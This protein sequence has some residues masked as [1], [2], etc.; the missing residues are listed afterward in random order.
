MSKKQEKPQLISGIA[1]AP[2][3]IPMVAIENRNKLKAVQ[4]RHD[5][6][7]SPFQPTPEQSVTVTATS[8]A[9]MPLTHAEIWYTTDGTWPNETS[10]RIPMNVHKV[11]RV[12]KVASVHKM[13]QV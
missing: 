9:A 2:G 10:Q 6:T 13:I 1:S 11:T 5:N 12:L 7:I 3:D 8:G 4:F